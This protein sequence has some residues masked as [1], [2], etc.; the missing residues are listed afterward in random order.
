MSTPLRILFAGTPDFAERHLSALLDSEHDV[1]A[2]LTQPDR[3][4]GRGK[5]L[6]PSP[7]K[8][9]ALD[10]G[11]EVLQPLSLK[12]EQVQ[13][14][15]AAFQADVMVVVAYGLILP[16]A[17]LDLPRYGC[18]NVHASILPRWRGAAP[19]QRAVEAGDA[20]SGVTIMQMEAGLDTGPMLRV[21]TLTLAADETGGSLHDK[22]AHSGP[23]ALLAVL[24]TIETSLAGAVVQD[25]DSA[26]YA[27]KID[28]AE[29]ELDWC[30]PAEVL[31]RQIR[32]FNPVPVCF[33]HLGGERVKVWT[34]VAQS[35]SASS[36]TSHTNAHPGT[37]VGVRRDGIDVACGDGLLTI[38]SAQ[39]PGGKAQPV[40]SL[41]NGKAEV[42]AVGQQFQTSGSSS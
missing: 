16:Q 25:H 7:V 15:L 22:L 19:I 37:I 36:A 11:L 8:Q 1:I 6:Q 29:C 2:V 41:L 17:V 12:S 35:P 5:K 40:A 21:E 13:Q 32:A 30:Q 38:T 20:D 24:D 34:A 31:E 10:A 42:L 9:R 3:P 39:F 23:P 27:H 18:L 33:S 28:K 26:T 14:A 4:A